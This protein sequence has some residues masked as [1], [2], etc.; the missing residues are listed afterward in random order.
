MN[1]DFEIKIYEILKDF[2]R[3]V[4]KDD[5]QRLREEFD[6]SAN[7]AEEIHEMIAEYYPGDKFSLG[8]SPFE[9]AFSKE[10]VTRPGVELFE[11]NESDRWGVECVLWNKG[12]PSEPILHV[13]FLDAPSGLK[14]SY[15]YIGS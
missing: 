14:L 3:A 2:V 6:I 4:D 10:G 1:P 7:L 11:M 8:I 5:R 12:V 15:K 9:L 13:E